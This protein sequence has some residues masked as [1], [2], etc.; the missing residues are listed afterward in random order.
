MKYDVK[1]F[2]LEEKL[3]LLTGKDQWSVYNADGKVK[4]VIMCDGPHGAK[5]KLN[6]NASENI[7]MP[8]LAMLANSW[9]KDAAYLDGKILADK[10]VDNGMDVLLAPGV[11]V[12]RTPLCGR[13]F[14]YFSEDPYLT[15]EL[16]KSYVCGLQD[17]GIGATVKHYCC[18]NREFDRNYQSSEVDERTL[19]EIYLPAFEKTLEAKP[20]AV[21]C[22]YNPINGVYA[23]ENKYLLDDVLR[24]ELGFDGLI[25]SDWAAVHSEFRRIR[26]GLDLRM[27]Y[28][29][30]SFNDLKAAYDKGLITDE[31]ID[32]CVTR[33]LELVE[34]TEN[35]KKKVEYT[36]EERYANAVSIAQ[37]SIVLLKNEDGILPLK[38]GK[39]LVSGNYALTPP[40]GGGGSSR[41]WTEFKHKPLDELL[42]EKLD[43]KA[44]VKY[45][46]D[47]KVLP[48]GEMR[49][50]RSAFVAAY[51]SDAV[52][53]CVGDDDTIEREDY[54]RESIRLTKRQEEFIKNTAKANKNVIV[55][56]YS[57]SAIDMSEWVD[58][59]KAVVYAGFLGNA[60]ND[61]VANVLTGEAVP[62]GKLAETFPWSLE[63]TYTGEETGDGFAE[64]YTDGV[65]VGY[66]Y[67]EKVGI[68]V[69]FPFGHGLS[70]ADFTYG[71]LKI[72]K[73]GETDYEV[74][75]DITNNSDYAAKEVS[76]LYVKD[77]FSMV[78]RPEKELKG[79][80]KD[81]I[82]A[83][84]TKTITLK[85]D[86]RSFA[87]F[88]T[89]LRRWHV[90][91]GAFEISVG[92]S[93]R[94]IR[95]CG[96][97]DIDLPEETQQTV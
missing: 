91:N 95:L 65:F 30:D 52:V 72:K 48:I 20:W 92:A 38:S 63:D 37:E 73:N 22:S 24:K 82:G 83:H 62:S 44:T 29:P 74:S 27:P 90:E 55:V 84:E 21:M 8:N 31:Q 49:N 53:L 34:K 26:A 42:S 6:E 75:Y 76:Q 14:E 15:G 58:D 7:A 57:G 3:K 79:F 51:D 1:N 47:T 39:I 81:E 16:A 40:V 85:L 87:F 17:K 60:A 4:D 56:L 54:D 13:N 33:I 23:S 11:N 41:V 25:V 35:D 46:S 43:G 96:R 36:V 9:S 12:K 66:R 28:S 69:M 88:N 59:V 89:S 68:P 78:S 19:R 77:V 50:V 18:N 10:C 61:A 45:T 67:Y 70:Y 93:S 94:D 97:I 2:T 80:S 86:F 71:N 64:R 5:A 32:A